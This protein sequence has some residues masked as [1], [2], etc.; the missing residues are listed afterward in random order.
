MQK[1]GTLDRELEQS[2]TE[3]GV[4]WDPSDAAFQRG[5]GE[6]MA[7][8]SANGHANVPS[9]YVS[10]TGFR[11]GNWL[12]NQKTKA[13]LGD[14]PS[15]RAAE[16]LA[17]GFDT[18]RNVPDE[19]WESHSGALRAW[20]EE[21]AHTNVPRSHVMEGGIKLGQWLRVQRA[22]DAGGKLK[23]HRRQRLDGLDPGWRSPDAIW[24]DSQIIEVLREAATMAY[25]LTID[26]YESMRESGLLRG[27]AVAVLYRRFG[28]WVAACLAAGVESGRPTLSPGGLK[29]TNSDVLGSIESFLRLHG[30][31]ATG[32]AY[33][34]WARQHVDAPSMGTVTMRFGTWNEAKRQLYSRR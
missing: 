10:R 27:P 13:R 21:H 34:E 28:S 16:L 6:L 2:L 12:T 25:P 15:D 3:I 5:L 33:A 17:V 9:G 11:L 18:T 1:K 14:M 22:W 31:D 30:S 8:E 32:K 7:Y 29:F 4:V 24:P 19:V 20:F 26:Q 23:G